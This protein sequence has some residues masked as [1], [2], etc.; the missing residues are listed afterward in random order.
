MDFFKGFRRFALQ[1]VGLQHVGAKQ[2][3]VMASQDSRSQ[4][5]LSRLFCIRILDEG[6]SLRYTHSPPDSVKSSETT[7][8]TKQDNS[9]I[10]SL[11]TRNR[12]QFSDFRKSLFTLD[13][14]LAVFSRKPLVLHSQPR[15]QPE[16]AE[17]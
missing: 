17:R 4:C 14:N 6:L 10:K 9:P 2:T 15:L 12:L 16:T 13:L 1:G 5:F 11:L 8:K 3:P 7:H